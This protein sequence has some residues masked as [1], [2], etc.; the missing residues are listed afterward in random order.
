MSNTRNEIQLIGCQSASTAILRSSL[1][2]LLKKKSQARDLSAVKYT[3]I[4]AGH[5]QYSYTEANVNHGYGVLIY[6]L[7][8]LVIFTVFSN[9]G[10]ALFQQTR[11]ILYTEI[12]DFIEKAG[13]QTTFSGF[14]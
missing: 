5:S 2:V 10:N 14:S 9:S 3:Y 6:P 4:F 7:L 11:S 12:S 8:S 1:N 13:H